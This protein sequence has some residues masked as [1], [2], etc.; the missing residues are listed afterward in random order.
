MKTTPVWRSAVG[1]DRNANVGVRV[2]ADSSSLID[3]RT[4]PVVV[5]AGEDHFGTCLAEKVGDAHRDIEVVL[6]FGVAI[7]GGRPNRVAGSRF[8]A[9]IDGLIDLLGVLRVLAVVAG[10]DDDALSL[11]RDKP[12]GSCCGVCRW[13]GARRGERRGGCR[14][15]VRCLGSH[16]R[17]SGPGV[18]AM[19]RIDERSPTTPTMSNETA[20]TAA[21]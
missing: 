8:G 2:V 1:V 16:V 4:P 7:V 18:A 6:R 13:L 10:V 15:R 11:C 19:A 3:A 5:G 9:D 14:L 12:A 21:A 20:T 17:R